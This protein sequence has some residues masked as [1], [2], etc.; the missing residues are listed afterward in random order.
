MPDGLREQMI[1]ATNPALVSLESGVASRRGAAEAA[2]DAVI[3]LLRTE[4]PAA[5][6]GALYELA[7]HQDDY[8]GKGREQRILDALLG[9]RP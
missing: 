9:E 8:D 5:I 1:A 7:T 6:E 2:V 3:S 4:G